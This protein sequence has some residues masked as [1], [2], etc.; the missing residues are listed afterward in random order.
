MKSTR[1]AEL[2]VVLRGLTFLDAAPDALGAE[3]L[4]LLHVHAVVLEGGGVEPEGLDQVATTA[5]PTRLVTRLSR[6]RIN[7]YL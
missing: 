3:C 4:T 6:L 2:A 1:S 7:K 5:K